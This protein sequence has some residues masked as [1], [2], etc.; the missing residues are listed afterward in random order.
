MS[1][2]KRFGDK[3]MSPH[4]KETFPMGPQFFYFHK[5]Y[6]RSFKSTLKKNNELVCNF[7]AGCFSYF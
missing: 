5:K 2:G 6:L 7:K 4:V 1:S 3:K